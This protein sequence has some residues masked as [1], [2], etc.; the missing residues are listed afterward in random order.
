ME[1]PWKGDDFEDHLYWELVKA[2]GY[3]HDAPLKDEYS[4]QQFMHVIRLRRPQLVAEITAKIRLG[5]L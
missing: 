2:T 5:L 3:G 4:R 1:Y